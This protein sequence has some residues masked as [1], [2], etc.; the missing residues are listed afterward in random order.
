MRVQEAACLAQGEL[1]RLARIVTR[2]DHH[3]LQKMIRP[4]QICRDGQRSGADAGAA[5]NGE[6]PWGP[7]HLRVGAP[8]SGTML[9]SGVAQHTLMLVFV[10]QL[11][12]GTESC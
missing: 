9:M 1:L 5:C 7:A 10:D 4:Q 8:I 2:S 12:V 6:P 3:L 11:A